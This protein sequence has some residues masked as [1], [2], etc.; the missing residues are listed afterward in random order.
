MARRSF[1]VG[2]I[3]GFALIAM[4]TFVFLYVPIVTLIV[5]SFNAAPSMA[6]WQG[7]S[8]QWYEAAFPTAPCGTCRS[9]R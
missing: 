4:L 3:P 2:R 1:S 7:F 5:F 8:L 6:V 9:V